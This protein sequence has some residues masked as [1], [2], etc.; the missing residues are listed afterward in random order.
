VPLDRKWS[1]S[2]P[3]SCATSTEVVARGCEA[4]RA[5]RIAA[6]GVVQCNTHVDPIAWRDGRRFIGAERALDD[7]VAHLALRREGRVDADEP[8]GLLT[9]HLVFDADAWRFVGELVARTCRHAAARWM[10]VDEAFGA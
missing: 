2:S 8:T 6:S 9:H 4:A 10:S 1:A 3:I 7:V 5:S